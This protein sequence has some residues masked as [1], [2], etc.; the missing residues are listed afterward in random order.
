M[1]PSLYSIKLIKNIKEVAEWRLCVGCG[2][3]AYACPEGN[4]QLVDIIPDG[5][6]PKVDEKGCAS[7]G[8]CLNVCPGYETS[9][10]IHSEISRDRILGNNNH[11][12]ECLAEWG[13]ILE[14]WEGY[15]TDPELRSSGSSGGLVSAIAAY[16][17]EKEGMYGALHTGAD[18][19][20]PWRNRTTVSRTRAE[21]LERTGSRYSPASPCDGFN[22]IESAP[23][24]CVFIGKPCDVVAL[25]K[26][27][28]I[29]PELDS[30]VGLA[31]GFFC[32]GTPATLGIL[33]LLK[34][35]SIDPDRI[36][37]IR[38]RGNGWP[39]KFTVRVNGEKDPACEISY[40]ESWGFLQKYRP[41]RCHL[42]PDGTGEFAD[43]A[44]GDPWYREIR[45]EE[46]G[47]SL[48]LV[49][50]EKGKKILEGV[51]RSGYAV[52]KP[53]S[54]GIILRSQWNLLGKRSAIWGR[55]V[56][57]RSFGVPTP[58]LSGFSLF[59]NWK[60]IPLKDKLRSIFG[61]ARRIIQRG[62]YRPF[63]MYTTFEM[64]SFGNR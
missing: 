4:V 61:T 29:R 18:E 58:R 45:S 3:C 57:M 1:E 56:A 55:L 62:Y 59:E 64:K 43:I 14:V 36:E 63:K 30:N 17:I 27:Q 6:R 34:R 10:G 7:C 50:T 16:C 5:I 25:R 39:G 24:S 8:E 44:C 9:H 41:Y 54:P 22:A 12:K 28:M 48:V 33:E 46:K 31:I 49:R 15:A 23:A 47:A 53:S 26:T 51:I 35:S 37:E 2:A 13:P 32:A 52:L 40:K 38:F 60:R 11:L 42:C 20:F 19:R 21:L